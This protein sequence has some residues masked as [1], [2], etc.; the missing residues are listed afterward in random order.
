MTEKLFTGTLNKN[1]NKKS[2]AFSTAFTTKV[3]PQCRAFSM[4]LK[5][6]KIKARLLRS[7]NGAGDTKDCYNIATA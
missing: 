4:A 1:Q 3:V 7:P 5:I 2:M 6:E